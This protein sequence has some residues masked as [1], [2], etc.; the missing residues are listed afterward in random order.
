MVFKITVIIAMLSRKEG[1][2]DHACHIYQGEQS[3]RK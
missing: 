3:A 2:V 1:K